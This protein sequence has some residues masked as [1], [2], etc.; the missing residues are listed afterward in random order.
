MNSQAEIAVLE[1]GLEFRCIGLPCK[2]TWTPTSYGAS[3]YITLDKPSGYA[4]IAWKTGR[5][6]PLVVAPRTIWKEKPD[7]HVLAPGRASFL[8]VAD[9]NRPLSPLGL[10]IEQGG[11]SWSIN[12]QSWNYAVINIIEL[13][14]A[15]L[16]AIEQHQ[17]FDS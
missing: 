2:L 1:S 5:W 6:Q 7:K 13:I 9:N 3:V 10:D 15:V 14:P 11:S 4:S 12:A 16:E 17:N 8:I